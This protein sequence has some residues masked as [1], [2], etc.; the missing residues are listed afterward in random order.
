MVPGGGEPGR[1]SLGWYKKAGEGGGADATGS[2]GGGGR[3]G[4][5]GGIRDGGNLGVEGK[6]LFLRR[7]VLYPSGDFSNGSHGIRQAVHHSK[8]TICTG[9]RVGKKGEG[10]GKIRDTTQQTSWFFMTRG[11]KDSRIHTAQKIHEWHYT[12]TP[13]SK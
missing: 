7:N 5:G 11:D 8:R 4:R 9:V 13:S 10:G 1:D 12:L 2:V 3:K 6:N